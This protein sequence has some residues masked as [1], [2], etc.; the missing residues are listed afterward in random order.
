MHLCMIRF[1][2]NTNASGGK[3]QDKEENNLE[4]G[5][6]MKTLGENNLLHVENKNTSGEN[7][8][9]LDDNIFTSVET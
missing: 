7:M 5:E 9:T 3:H 2:D 6:N 4:H 1:V 8:K